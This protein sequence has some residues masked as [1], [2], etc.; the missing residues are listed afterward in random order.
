[1][2]VQ[3]KVSVLQIGLLLSSLFATNNAFQTRNTAGLFG[4]K[5][6][7]HVSVP[8]NAKPVR[9]SFPLTPLAAS[10]VFMADEEGSDEKSSITL[11]DQLRK[12]TGFS[13]TAFRAAWR[14]ATGISLTAIYAATLAASGLWIRKITTAVLSIFPDWVSYSYEIALSRFWNRAECLTVLV[15]LLLQFRYFLQPFLIAYYLPIFVIR[16]WTAPSRRQGQAHH[17]ALKSSWKDAVE[18]AEMT[19]SDGYWPVQVNG[20]SWSP[21]S[22]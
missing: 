8:S 18:F 19:Q 6:A 14:A 4:T 16:S 13:L 10:R 3:K 5:I 20:R 22:Q 12:A 9:G 21:R 11:R 17:D 1:M 15:S 2:M 7:P